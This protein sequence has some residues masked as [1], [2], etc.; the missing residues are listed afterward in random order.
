MAAM[1]RK[2][3]S[4]F[5]Y[6]FTMELIT[7]LFCYTIPMKGLGLQ[8]LLFDGVCHDMVQNTTICGDR[9]SASNDLVQVQQQT[10]LWYMYGNII[11]TVPAVISSMF[12][13]RYVD[14]YGFALPFK[15]QLGGAIIGA[16]ALAG[17]AWIESHYRYAMLVVLTLGLS[18]YP[19]SFM[20]SIFSYIALSTNEDQRAY[21]MS[22]IVACL[23]LAMSAGIASFGPIVDN[24]GLHWVFAIQV[25]P[26][27]L[28][29]LDVIYRIL[30]HGDRKSTRLNSSHV[31]TSRMPSSA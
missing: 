21:R 9:Y 1:F 3:E 20:M 22:I 28:A 27:S 7:V 18:G 4:K 23:S 17:I 31:R 16:V 30:P 12:Q 29:L 13:G 26:L 8:A 19:M 6:R 2:L 24:L 10:S 11:L 5:G 25:I 15:V 14:L